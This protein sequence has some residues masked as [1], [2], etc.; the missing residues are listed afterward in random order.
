MEDSGFS[1]GGLVVRFRFL[2]FVWIAV[3]VAVAELRE[4]WLDFSGLFFVDLWGLATYYSSGRSR[5]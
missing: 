3:A 2:R 4:A 1:R 5:G